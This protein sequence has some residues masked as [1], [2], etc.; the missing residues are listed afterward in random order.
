MLQSDYVRADAF[1]KLL[2]DT[3][4]MYLK[5]ILCCLVVVVITV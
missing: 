1:K 3:V 5:F 4:Y 2:V